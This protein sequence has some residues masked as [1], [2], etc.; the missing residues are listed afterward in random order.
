MRDLSRCCSNTTS[1]RRAYFQENDHQFLLVE[2]RKRTKRSAIG[3]ISRYLQ[4]KLVSDFEESGHF[5][6][7]IFPAALSPSCTALTPNLFSIRNPNTKAQNNL[8]LLGRNPLFLLYLLPS[9]FFLF[10]SKSLDASAVSPNG[11]R[12]RAVFNINNQVVLKSTSYRYYYSLTVII[13]N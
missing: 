1:D 6:L 11:K 13:N 9:I 8:P 2:G 3:S 4:L 5:L 10:P 12:A 7:E